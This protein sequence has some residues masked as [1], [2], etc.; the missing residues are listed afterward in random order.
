MSK[1]IHTKTNFYVTVK[2]DIQASIK[3]TK[4]RLLSLG[5]YTSKF[6]R[7]AVQEILKTNYFGCPAV[8]RYIGFPLPALFFWKLMQRLIFTNNRPTCPGF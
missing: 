5:L 7:G 8:Y 3:V 6:L 4:K 2:T 1:K